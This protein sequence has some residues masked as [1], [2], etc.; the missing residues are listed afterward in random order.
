MTGRAAPIRRSMRR[1]IMLLGL[2][3]CKDTNPRD[4]RIHVSQPTDSLAAAL[5]AALTAQDAHA[6]AE[7]IICEENKLTSRYGVNAASTMIATVTDTI[8]TWRDHWAKA[9]WA[10]KLAGT[11]GSADTCTARDS[12]G[13]RLP[14]P[15]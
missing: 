1:M 14:D 3:A 8:Y 4:A 6:A 10:Q 15:P 5:R 7:K 2:L 11:H 9:R 13:R 12:L